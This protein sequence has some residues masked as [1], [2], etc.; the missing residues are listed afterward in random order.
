MSIR[1][2]ACNARIPADSRSCAG[3]AAP[4]EQARPTAIQR[5]TV[6]FSRLFILL[7]LVVNIIGWVACLKDID[8]A[9]M[10]GLLDGLLGLI[11]IVVG[12]IARYRWAWAIGLAHLVLPFAMFGLVALF[13]MGPLQARPAFLR[14]DAVFLVVMV[15]LSIIACLRG[16]AIRAFKHPGL[17]GRCGYPLHGLTEPRCPECGTP[18]DPKLLTRQTSPSQGPAA[19]A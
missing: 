14:A 9:V 8:T 1:C 7:A 6:M 11:L 2:P 13:N 19:C 4:L 10:L 5:T 12:L 18:F 16:P 15:P 3:C 17:C